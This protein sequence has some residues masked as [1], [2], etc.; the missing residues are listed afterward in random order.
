MCFN[1]F[2]S[3][4]N[5]AEKGAVGGNLLQKQVFSDSFVYI[6]SN[7]PWLIVFSTCSKFF[8]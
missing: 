2:Q 5:I 1:H 4:D 7:I 8:M 3:Y 6:N